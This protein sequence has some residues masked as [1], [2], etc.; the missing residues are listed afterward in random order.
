MSPI[1]TDRQVRSFITLEEVIKSVENTWRWHGEERIVSS[2]KVTTDMQSA[3][4]EGWFD[5]M[6][7]YVA[8]HDMAG[9]KVVGGYRTT[10]PAECLT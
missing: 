7:S 6:P 8:P 2:S 1:I 4:V 3:G 10:H 5:S 9:I